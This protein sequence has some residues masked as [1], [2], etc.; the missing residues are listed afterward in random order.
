MEA[1]STPL[2]ETPFYI[3]T[4]AQEGVKTIYAPAQEGAKVIDLPWNVCLL[5]KGVKAV[6]HLVALCN[7]E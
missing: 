7:P 3:V 2:R 5:Q 1:W 6:A 4:L